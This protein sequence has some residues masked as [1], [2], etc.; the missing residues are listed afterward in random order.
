MSAFTFNGFIIFWHL[1]KFSFSIFPTFLENLKTIQPP[2]K[3]PKEGD[4]WNI[5]IGLD[6]L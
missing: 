6:I 3:K 1:G 2:I 4:K 5:F